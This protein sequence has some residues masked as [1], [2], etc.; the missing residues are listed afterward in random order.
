MKL[1][2][3]SV[4]T[5][6]QII[7]HYLL[8]FI[9]ISTFN[10]PLGTPRNKIAPR[11]PFAQLSS[12]SNSHVDVKSGPVSIHSAW[13][14]SQQLQT[15]TDQISP[16]LLLLPT[17]CANAI[18]RC[19]LVE[20]FLGR[21]LLQSLWIW[22]FRLLSMLRDRGLSAMHPISNK[23]CD[24]TPE[25][26]CESDIRWSETWSSNSL[27][28]LSVSRVLHRNLTQPDMTIIAKYYPHRHNHDTLWW[29]W[30]I[31]AFGSDTHS[32]RKNPFLG[33]L[34]ASFINP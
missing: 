4:Y 27:Y 16:K 25:P 14:N 8:I 28:R 26:G 3:W 34:T 5:I 32:C 30:I 10:S 13:S 11:F 1:I 15:F 2:R 21:N 31:T 24:S 33:S 20:Q 7:D 23:K 17:S 9:D 12:S 29:L 6:S 22:L 19:E 18:C